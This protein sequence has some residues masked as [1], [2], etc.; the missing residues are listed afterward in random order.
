MAR[1]LLNPFV[2]IFI[3]FVLSLAVIAKGDPA[4]NTTTSPWFEQVISHHRLH[5][6]NPRQLGCR[7]RP[8]ICRRGEHPPGVR[9]RCCRNQCVDVSSDVNHC[10]VPGG[11]AAFMECAV[12]RSPFFLR[13]FR[14]HHR[15][16]R[17][18]GCLRR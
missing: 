3:L 4:Q 7:W 17:R 18:A 14:R 2:S 15:L 11:A 8:W 1:L 6:S 13:L 5:R 16:C 10:G 12:M 9:M